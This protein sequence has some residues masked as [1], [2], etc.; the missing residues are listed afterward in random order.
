MELIG[1]SDA[2]ILA[3]DEPEIEASEGRIMTRVHVSRERNSTLVK[4]K[5]AVALR[6][7]GCLAC[8]VCGFDF[9]QTYGERGR[10]FI[11]CHHTL[12]ISSLGEHG[13]TNLKDLALVCS[14]CHR[15]I[16]ARR[17]WWSIDDAKAA[18]I[19]AN[20]SRAQS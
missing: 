14:N 19:G 4:K 9:L 7:H 17:P 5:K 11:E 2:E 1:D 18:L 12:P 8:E 6:Q 10:E 13:K 20:G 16:H 3:F 15:M